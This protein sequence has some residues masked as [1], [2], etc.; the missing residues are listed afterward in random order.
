[1]RLKAALL[2]AAFIVAPVLPARSY[3]LQYDRTGSVQIKW[4][5]RSITF[6]LSASLSAPPANV[7]PGS[8]VTGA[9]RRALQR[10]SEAA[11]LQFNVIVSSEERAQ[12]D[13]VS[14]ITVS[15]LNGQLF[16]NPETPGRARVFSS[17]AA[18]GAPPFFP[19]LESDVAVNPNTQFSTDGTPGTYD[20]ETT[21]VHEIG[22]ALGLEHSGLAGAVM[23]PRQARNGTFDLP[24][25]RR[26][27]LSDDDRAG[28]RALYGPADG[29]GELRGTVRNAGGTPF[30]GAHVFAEE[31][32]TGRAVAGNIT[33]PDGVYR[34]SALPP[35]RY[36]V[37][38]E[39]L[40]DPVLASEI[41]SRNGAYQGLQGPIPDFRTLELPPADVAADQATVLDVT[42]GGQQPGFNPRFVGANARLSTVPL[43]VVPGRS[44]TLYL[45]GDNLHTI[46]NGGDIQINSPYFTIDPSSLASFTFQ[47][48]SGPV[49]VLTVEVSTSILAAPGDYSVRLARRNAASGLVDEI[50]YLSGV[51]TI[52]PPNGLG[53]ADANLID[54]PQFFV[55]QHYRDFLSREPDAGGLQ[56]WTQQIVDCGADAQC[57]QIRRV[58]VSAA[59]F[60]SIEFQETGYFVYRV[61]QA[62]FGDINPPAVPVPV[63]FNRFFPDTQQIGRGVIV[64]LGDWEERLEANKRAF[65]L[66]FVT[67]PEFVARYPATLGPAQFVD[68]LNQNAGGALDAA[69]RA[70]LVADLSGR[71]TPEGRAD[72]LRRVAD[73]ADLVRDEFNSAFVLM[74]YFGYLRRNPDDFPDL[75]FAGYEFWLAKLNQFNG[76]FVQAE[77]VRAFIESIEYRRR[78]GT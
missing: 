14:L 10:W 39:P 52:D 51:L 63:R 57:R 12:Q 25:L 35:G 13:G 28:I 22:H 75:S 64:G 15:A 58:N 8:D 23:Q 47:G 60:L 41:P 3:T 16:S 1:M 48:P 77:M 5:T 73:D 6:A 30:F 26:R 31:V 54:D 66:D 61:H 36:R 43:Q 53:P 67:R 20:L 55:A 11:D 2:V 40:N 70:D 76:N 9:A 59:F 33:L 49:Q 72:A 4:P 56:F 7:R 69:E 18:Q 37:V 38:V 50:T 34:I 27:V 45:G 68:A 44:F 71:N 19:I 29:L 17:T 32:T 74:Q 62:A 24:A 42:L 78:F 46:T 65:L 21:F